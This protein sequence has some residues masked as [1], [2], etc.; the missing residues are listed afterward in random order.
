MAQ[1]PF[2]TAAR[3]VDVKEVATHM[4]RLALRRG[5]EQSMSGRCRWRQEW[6]GII[7]EKTIMEQLHEN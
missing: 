7:R 1:A 5:A 4:F 3:R 2:L 6:S